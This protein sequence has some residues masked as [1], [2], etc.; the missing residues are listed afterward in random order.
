[1]KKRIKTT[2][3]DGVI[4]PECDGLGMVYAS[5]EASYNDRHYLVLGA[6]PICEGRGVLKN[7]NDH[8]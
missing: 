5:Y 1:M 2:K 3:S 7:D 8:D 4:C 6:C